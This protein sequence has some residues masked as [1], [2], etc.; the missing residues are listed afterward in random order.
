MKK[1]KVFIFFLIL[2]I[3]NK[4]KGGI[5]KIIKIGFT[6][7]SYKLAK[8]KKTKEKLYEKWIYIKQDKY[9][10]VGNAWK[11]WDSSLVLAR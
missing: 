9:S 4:K 8:R 1:K 10:N 6:S 7:K 3:K 11:I 2:K 5:E